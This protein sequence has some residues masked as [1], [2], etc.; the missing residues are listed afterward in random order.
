MTK[1]LNTSFS[2]LYYEKLINGGLQEDPDQKA[3]VKKMQ[4]VFE[5]I[6][7]FY[8]TSSGFS[9]NQFFSIT[10]DSEKP[11][12]KGI[13]L[14]GGVGRGK[15]HL[16]DMFYDSLSFENK[17]RLH[18]H[19]FMQL[20]HESLEE[21]RDFE[22][23]LSKIAKDFSKKYRVIC[24]DE[25]FVV[26]ITDA[27]LLGELFKHL[28]EKGVTLLFTSNIEPSEQYKNFLQRARFLHAI[29]FLVKHS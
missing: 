2:D 22:L 6:E 29:D 14:W 3:A 1:I 19:R 12:I 23:P 21:L 24:L 17:L 7:S 27:M 16:L 26:D 5:Q 25:I 9:L 28:I 4:L 15:T 20:I 8:Q 13:Y 18:F 10:S 11:D